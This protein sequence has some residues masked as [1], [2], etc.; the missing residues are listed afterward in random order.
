MLFTII[1]KMDFIFEFKN[2]SSHVIAISCNHYFIIEQCYNSCQHLDMVT[3]T[4]II[5]SYFL[6]KA[7]TDLKMLYVR[8]LLQK[9]TIT[10]LRTSSSIS[11]QIIA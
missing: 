11:Y 5:S 9:L 6:D 2:T 7:K 3:I 10:V 8:E 4:A 1:I